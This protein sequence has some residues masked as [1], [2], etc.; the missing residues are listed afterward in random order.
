MLQESV[1]GVFYLFIRKYKNI[2]TFQA[3][4]ED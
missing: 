4:T 2:K 1:C 3:I